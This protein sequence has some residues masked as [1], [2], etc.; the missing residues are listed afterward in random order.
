MTLYIN[1]ILDG[2]IKLALFDDKNRIEKV[3]RTKRGQAEKLL[4]IVDKLMQENSISWRSIKKIIVA[5]SGGSFTSLRIGVLT[6]NA[7]AYARGIKVEGESGNKPL[8]FKQFQVVTPIYS[9][10]P[11]IGKSKKKVL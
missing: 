10:E 3:S 9:G 2:K 11:N 7:L 1:T 6:A 4:V 8:D 5:D